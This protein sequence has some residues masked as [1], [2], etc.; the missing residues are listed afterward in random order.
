MAKHQHKRGANMRTRLMITAL[1]ILLQIAVFVIIIYSFAGKKIWVYATFQLISFITVTRIVTK[2]GN[3]SYKLMWI[4]FIIIQK[5][6]T[7]LV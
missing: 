6:G 4:I 7:M 5:S 1:F 2:R 3:P